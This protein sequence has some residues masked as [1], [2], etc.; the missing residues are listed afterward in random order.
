MNEYKKLLNETEYIKL[1]IA[2]IINRFGDS[3][4]TIAYMW[5]VYALTGKASL[6]AL[7]YAVNK[8]PTVL[9]QPITGAWVEKKNKKNVIML[10]DAIR[11]GL[12][13]LLVI[14]SMYNSLNYWVLVLFTLITSIVETFRVPTAVSFLPSIVNKE[15]YKLGIAL[16]SSLSSFAELLGLSLAGVIIEISG[17]EIAIM[18]D[19]V[20]F[21]L[22]LLIISTIKY[23]H[24]VGDNNSTT[25]LEQ[26]IEGAHYVINDKI[27]CNFIVMAVLINALLVP[28]NSLLIPLV[29]TVA[30]SGIVSE[31]NSLMMRGIMSGLFLLVKISK[32]RSANNTIVLFGVI[33]SNCYILI[34]AIP[35][36]HNFIFLAFYCALI[37]FT[38]GF[39]VGIINTLL[40]TLILQSVNKAYLSRVSAIFSACSNGI[41]PVTS[42][43]ISMV[44]LKIDTAVIFLF[45]GMLSLLIF[46][47][48]KLC[49]VSF[50][51]TTV[52]GGY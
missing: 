19:A 31:I 18:I 23:T 10:T 32:N 34:S 26:L 1:L 38:F 45:C 43:L 15:N 47:I 35:K 50:E 5:L 21:I 27:I 29:T 41:I 42:W 44:L 37:P 20:T 40:Q 17:V 2:N 39:G 3:I 28:I 51:K 6:T 52:E 8:I 22:S 7:I 13:T 33:I 9:L 46:I 24:Y 36:I 12:V 30:G 48:L 49:N 16:N 25:V 4:D 14:L 11:G